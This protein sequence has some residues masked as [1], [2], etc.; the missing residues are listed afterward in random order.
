MDDE[1]YEKDGGKGHREGYVGTSLCIEIVESGKNKRGQH[2]NLWHPG[3][4]LR[5]FIRGE[6]NLNLDSP[7]RRC[8]RVVVVVVYFVVGRALKLLLEFFAASFQSSF[9]APTLQPSSPITPNPVRVLL[10]FTYPA[11]G[12]LRQAESSSR[13]NDVLSS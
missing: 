11:Y 10:D 12:L 6:F 1:V 7:R 5:I 8:R 13:L 2:A 9:T 4:P 3:A